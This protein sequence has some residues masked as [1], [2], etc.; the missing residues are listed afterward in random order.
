MTAVT[1]QA[2]IGLML[3]TPSIS[4]FS[5]FAPPLAVL[6]VLAACNSATPA[7]SDPPADPV[8]PE[9]VEPLLLETLVT[10]MSVD[11]VEG[12]FRRGPV[13]AASGDTRPSIMISG[14]N[15]VV[16][17]GVFDLEIAPEDPDVQYVVDTLYVSL[18]GEDRGYYELDLP[19]VATTAV[20][21]ASVTVRP[22]RVVCATNNPPCAPIRL[23]G[24]VLRELTH[25]EI[26]LAI[27]MAIPGPVPTITPPVHRVLDV[28]QVG[29]GEVQVSLTWNVESDVDLHVVD[30][31]GDEIYWSH[32]MVDSGGELDLDSNAGCSI[33]GIKNENIT[34]S[35]ESA[36]SGT[37]IV[38]VNYWSSCGVESTNY[39]VRINNGGETHVFEGTLTGR[40]NRGAEGSGFEIA[41]FVH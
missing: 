12:V 32:R 41:R 28:I 10:S 37:Y 3:V 26:P 2:I 9:S 8:Q 21:A 34:W 36:P 29:S 23:R 7:Q 1:R 33:D 22:R 11:G 14:N 35:T 17:G 16:N 40:G 4:F 30:P 20:R 38:R 27:Q 5:R 15:N 6:L 19:T 31:A 25:E 18:Q 13:P 24:H 39:T